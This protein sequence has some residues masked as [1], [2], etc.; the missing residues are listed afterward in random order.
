[1]AIALVSDV[2]VALGLAP[3]T[4]NTAQTAQVQQYLDTISGWIADIT[5]Y[6]FGSTTETV[7]MQADGNGELAM[8]RYEPVSAINTVLDF[9]TQMYLSAAPG[10]GPQVYYFD[11]IDTI[12]GLYPRQVVDVNL[13]Y[14]DVNIPQSLK[15]IAVSA[16]KRA[17]LT[18]DG[19]SVKTVGEVSEEYVSRDGALYFTATER[20]ILAGW[21]DSET[22]WKLNIRPDY[23]DPRDFWR[24]ESWPIGPWL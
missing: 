4:L 6:Q 20:E 23:P 15:G 22:S 19:L 10:T 11:G 12:F 21:E 24:T 7:R 1:M 18:P 14:G 3:D 17:Y 9:K 2:E 16:A 8:T 13:T 5:G